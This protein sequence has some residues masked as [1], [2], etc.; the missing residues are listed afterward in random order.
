MVELALNKLLRL[1]FSTIGLRFYIS[2]MD[3]SQQ[4][5]E[6]TS[7]Y[8][9]YNS[10]FPKCELQIEKE[11]KRIELTTAEGNVIKAS[12][13]LRGWSQVSPISTRHYETFEAMMQ[14]LSPS[15]RDRFS[16]ELTN[17]L[18]SLLQ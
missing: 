4:Q 9:E 1:F 14:D 15:F 2:Q 10:F 18:N 8:Q 7:I 17:R 5:H 11:P 6:L 12:V 13:D 3:S 16:S